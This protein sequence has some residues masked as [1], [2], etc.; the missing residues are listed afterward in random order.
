MEMKKITSKQIFTYV[1]LFCIVIIVAVYAFVYKK[2]KDLA[3][4]TKAN[5]EVLEQRVNKLKTYYDNEKQ[6]KEDMVPLKE[7]IVK[8]L[9]PYPSNIKEEDAIM[10]A[11]NT[12]RA[13]EVIYSGI[14]I[15]EKGVYK[16][17]P[18]EVVKNAGMEEFQSAINFEQRRVTYPNVVDYENLKLVVQSLF[19]SDYPI[20]ITNISY[21]PSEGGSLNGVLDL[22]FYSVSG[23]GKEYV[24]PDILPYVSGT[25]NI[26]ANSEEKK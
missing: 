19:D 9:E 10:Q 23:T 15:G 6:Y 4:E 18:A 14:N 25:E 24:K 13:T 8:I 11:V 17:I 16:G 2:N 21:T 7:D 22:V 26:F 1:L 3:K 20:G 12:Q 5:N